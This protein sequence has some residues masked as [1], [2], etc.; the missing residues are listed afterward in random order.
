MINVIQLRNPYGLLAPEVEKV[1]RKAVAANPLLAPGGFDSVAADFWQMVTQD[2]FFLVLG[3]EGTFAKAVAWGTFPTSRM[4]PTPTIN[5]VYSEGS[6]ALMVALREKL[7]EV[8]LA[9]GY[10]TAWAVNITG[11][12]D[13]AWTKVFEVPGKTKISVLGSVMQLSVI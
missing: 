12:S 11:N 1:L 8:L 10:T 7:L 4:F 9:R 5:M 3:Y 6:R 13:K 2:N